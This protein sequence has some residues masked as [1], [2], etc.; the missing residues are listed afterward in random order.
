M[1]EKAIKEG[2]EKVQRTW[3]EF[4]KANDARLEALEKNKGVAEVQEK[5]E[6]MNTDI[7]SRM[8]KLETAQNR[9]VKTFEAPTEKDELQ[10]EAKAAAISYLRS[11]HIT[12]EQRIVLEKAKDLNPEYKA[13]SVDSDPDGGFLV[14]AE[15]A[16]EM[17]KR[18]F[19]SSPMRQLASVQQISSD[20]LEINYDDDE[21]GSGWV[22]EQQSR[23]ETSSNQLKQ[24]RIPAHELYAN[25]R[26]TQKLLD[27]AAVDVEAWHAGKVT[28]KFARDEATAFISGD[29]VLKPKGILSYPSTSSD[30]EFG[31]LQQVNSG[32]A[33]AVTAE[34]LIDLQ[35]SLFEE[36][37]SGASFLM[38]RATSADERK[39][40]NTDGNYLWNF[41][42]ITGLNSGPMEM[43]LG[44][45]VRFAS[46]MPAVAG[47][48]LAISYG[49]YRRGYQIVDRVGIRVLR[50]PFTAKPFIQ[51]YTTK[52]VGGAV[53]Q[54]QAIKLQKLAA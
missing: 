29:G 12:D 10:R 17:Q 39:L 15:I 22:G 41:Q 16:T 43:L 3:E 25:P 7:D 14:R 30:N 52:R 20:A 35:N 46:D 23:P 5:L 54:F 33:G 45:P 34:G 31:K 51:F 4:K 27:D 50:D 37:Q 24:L 53:K 11:G 48:A 26:A 9:A 1:E 21:P 8:E 38:R 18:V 47:D 13:L 36:F 28:E 2:F 42:P 49:D 40:K 19:E 6:K 44:K 32:S